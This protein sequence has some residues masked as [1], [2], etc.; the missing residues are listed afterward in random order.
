MVFMLGWKGMAGAIVLGTLLFGMNK[1]IVFSV[2]FQRNGRQL[3]LLEPH[4]PNHSS[5]HGF[6]CG[7]PAC[8]EAVFRSI[9][10]VS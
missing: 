10:L 4:T 1:V 6:H 2:Y 3:W 5:V 8:L 9:S 7:L